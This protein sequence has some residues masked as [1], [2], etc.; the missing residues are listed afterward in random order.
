MIKRL[1]QISQNIEKHGF[2]TTLGLVLAKKFEGITEERMK[3]KRFLE[4]QGVIESTDITRDDL[5]NHFAITD[6]T[7]DHLDKIKSVNWF[8]PHFEHVLYGGIYII[9]KFAEYL[10][11]KKG[12]LQRIIIFEEIPENREKIKKT[13]TDNFHGLQKA[14]FIIFNGEID[15]L[16]SCDASIATFWKSCYISVKFNKTKKKFYFIQD[17]EPLFYSAGSYHALA[18]A[19]YR[20]HFKGIVN[21]PGLAEYLKRE[22]Q[23]K[24]GSFYPCVN[25]DIYHISDKYLE[26][27]LS[28]DRLT[29][30]FYGRPNHERNAFELGMTTLKK[31]KEKYKHNIRII[32]AG[33]TWE[34]KTYGVEGII[35]NFGRLGTL[36]KVAAL[37]RKCDIGLVFMFTKHTSYQPLEYMACGCAVVTNE[38]SANN[39]LLK[40]KE[41]VL[42]SE[43]FASCI[44]EK[45]S[46]L[47]ENRILR[48]K[49]ILNGLNEIRKYS[50][51]D[52]C[53]KIYHYISGEK[54]T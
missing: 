39:W 46:E 33:G 25:T 42:I 7:Q 45:I 23:I 26:Q 5:K 41:N 32:S 1:Q 22:H 31:L 18:K 10:Q 50:W 29:I 6:D 4:R 24:C 16:P 13:I 37:Y 27:K 35:E 47:I 11:E 51:N 54:V 3:I 34:E 15:K 43:P 21:T 19:T 38:N 9:L 48:E 12:I 49:L 2:K 8:I 20:L 30:F 40:D 14:E 28:K 53:A 52:Q 17:Y 44:I 36:E